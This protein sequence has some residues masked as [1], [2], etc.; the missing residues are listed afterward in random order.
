[1]RSGSGQFPC[2]DLL[3]TEGGSHEMKC[4]YHSGLG[5]VGIRGCDSGEMAWGLSETARGCEESC[6]LQVH[7]LGSSLDSIHSFLSWSLSLPLCQMGMNHPTAQ[8]Q[9]GETA[10]WDTGQG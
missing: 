4:W 10:G 6:E 3:G 9:P 5:E 2:C 7:S 8:R 1:M